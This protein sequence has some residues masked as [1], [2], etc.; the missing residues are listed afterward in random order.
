MRRLFK[1]GTLALMLAG[2]AVT[3]LLGVQPVAAQQAS[4][5]PV[6]SEMAQLTVGNLTGLLVVVTNRT[7]NQHA[8]VDVRV[9]V[10]AFARVANTFAGVENA[11]PGKVEGLAPDGQQVGWINHFVRAGQAQG[12]FYVV[13]DNS[14]RTFETW[15]WLWFGTGGE[16]GTPA[17]RVQGTYVSP[18]IQTDTPVSLPG[19]IQAALP[20]AGGR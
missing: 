1:A 5:P 14:G 6:I 7:T 20:G 8:F 16:F 10:P 4:W 2:L 11:N 17:G 3:P 9:Y 13:V 15:S 12:P 18:R 19:G